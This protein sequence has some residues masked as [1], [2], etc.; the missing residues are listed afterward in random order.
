M[1]PQSALAHRACGCPG[2]CRHQHQ[3]KQHEFSDRRLV[4]AHRPQRHRRARAGEPLAPRARCRRA[5]TPHTSAARAGVHSPRDGERVLEAGRVPRHER[6][7]RPGPRASITCSIALSSGRSV[8]GRTGR[9]RSAACAVGVAR[10]SATITVAPSAWRSRIRAPDDRVARRRVRAEQ[11][12]AVGERE[13]GVGR[14]R[15]VGAERA[16]VAGDRARHAQA[17]VRVD[18][19]RAE[20]ALGELVDRVVVLGQQLAGDVERDRV[21]ARARRRSRAAGPRRAPSA[22]S[23]PASAKRRVARAR[24]SGVVARSRACTAAPSSVGLRHVRPRLTGCARVAARPAHAAVR[25]RRPPGRSRSPQYGQRVRCRRRPRRRSWARAVSRPR[26]PCFE[27]DERPRAVRHQG[28]PAPTA[29][30][31]CGA[32]AAAY[33]RPA[34]S[35]GPRDA[36]VLRTVEERGVPLRAPLVRRRARP[37]QERSRSRSP[38]SS[39]RSRRASGSTARRSRARR[40]CASATSSPTPTRARS[41][42]CRGARTSLVGADVLRRP[43]ARRRRRS[44]ATRARRCARVLGA[45]RRPRLHDPGRRR[46]RVL[47]VRR[48]RP[49]ASAPQAARRRRLLRPH[50][51]RRGLGLPPPHDRPPRADGDPGQGVAPR[52][53]ARRSTRSS[54]HHT[55]ALS[56]ADAI[57]TF[58]LAR[59]GGRARARRL[60]DVHAQAARAARRQRACTCTS[61]CSTATATPSTT[62]DRDEPLSPTRPRVPRR[63]ARP[64]AAS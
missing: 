48:R 57:T 5:G 54:S 44:P 43:P 59:Q 61:R 20:E 25:A 58:R 21:R 24:S 64:R 56:M 52:G 38:S 55:D 62:P 51:A 7:R 13:V 8:P 4:R 2:Y 15:A 17:R 49:T 63:R 53:R 10:G 22:S 33:R 47:P 46:D 19:V 26:R 31:M 27:R 45:G 35:M 3:E 29:G 37:A 36:Y 1:L 11:Q 39:R 28:E 12:Q 40:G 9:C 14:R 32:P 41:R 18:V 16:R 42:C 50:A 60:R 6:A 30:R 23:Q 34:T